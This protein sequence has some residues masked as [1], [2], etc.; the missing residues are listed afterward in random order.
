M[1]QVRYTIQAAKNLKKHGNM[2]KRI[3]KAVSEYAADQNAHRN[4]VT[5]LVGTTGKRLRVADF[6]V[7]FEE[8]DAEIIVTKIG[9][10]GEIYD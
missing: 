8:T 1:K 2:S 7:I 9:P 10:R 6:R 4:Q 5:E 3:M